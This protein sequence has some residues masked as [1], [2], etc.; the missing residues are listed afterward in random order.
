ML[1]TSLYLLNILSFTSLLVAVN[2]TNSKTSLL[3]LVVMLLGSDGKYTDVLAKQE[4]HLFKRDTL[5]LRNKQPSERERDKGAGTEEVKDAKCNSLDH[6]RKRINNHEL[7]EPLHADRKHHTQGTNTVGKD[8][9]GNDPGNTVP[10]ETVEDGI[11]INHGDSG[12][13]PGVLGW[14]AVEGAAK[15]RVDGEVEHGYSSA[16]GT[17]KQGGTSAEFVDDEDHEDDCCGHFDESVDTSGEELDRGTGE[18]NGLEDGG[19]VVVDGV[20]SMIR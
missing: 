14:D 16:D 11:D 19:G 20:D 9:R 8:F 4:V 12:V 7:S 15:F 5:G 3:E 2:L 13:G 17:D 6:V 18:A 1:Y 10:G